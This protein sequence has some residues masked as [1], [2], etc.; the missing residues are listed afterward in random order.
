MQVLLLCLLL[1]CS[2]FAV[3]FAANCNAGY[4]GSWESH[5]ALLTLIDASQTTSTSPADLSG[6]G[7]TW[8]PQ[9]TVEHTTDSD[10]PCWDL[11]GGCLAT[12][13]RLVVGSSYTLF[14]YWK[15]G[16][17]S[18]KV[19][20][21]GGTY[22]DAPVRAKSHVLQFYAMSRNSGPSGYYSTGYLITL[23]TWQT[24]IV[25][26]VATN[27]ASGVGTATYY[28]NGVS[29]AGVSVHRGRGTATFRDVVE[30]F[31]RQN[32]I[33]FAPRM[34]ANALKDGKQI[35]LFGSV[36]VYFDKSVVF[37]LRGSLWFPT[38]FEDLVLAANA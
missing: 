33:P 15:P 24:L 20:H 34:G 32:D 17:A 21:H 8:N 22:F 5:P 28:V 16:S 18:N 9:N 4:T 13:S 14:Y 7:M 37:A 35:F 29:G 11:N 2:S 26:G 31:S 23:D 25:T 27:V 19:L 3:T 12:S 36:P 38:S 30:D 6:G 10:V 1:I